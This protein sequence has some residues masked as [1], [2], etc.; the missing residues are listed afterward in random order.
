MSF[1][2]PL[3]L[4]GAAAVALPILY[5][6]IRRS[7][8]HQLEFSSLLFLSPSPPR[9]TRRSRIEHWLL[10]LL[11][12]TALLLIA[13]A[14][15]RPLWRNFAEAAQSDLARRRVAIA[16]DVS[17]SM[18]RPGV[19]EDVQAAVNDRLEQLNDTDQ[20]ALYTFGETTQVI[21]P[22]D[23]NP[24]ED[25]IATSR[26]AVRDAL[27]DLKPGWGRSDLGS[28]MLT[29]SDRLH[30]L[31]AETGPVD[32]RELIVVG[33]HQQGT[34]L[35]VLRA[36]D[37]P[38]SVE[39]T[40]IRVG[41]HV[42][43]NAA[44]ELLSVNPPDAQGEASI[45]LRISNSEFSDADQFSLQWFD[46]DEQSV[47]EPITV[48]VPAGEARFERLTWPTPEFTSGYLLLQGDE[49]GFDNRCYVTRT[50][51]PE[52]QL[53]FVGPG[54]P[55]DKQTLPFY[56][57]RAFQSDE[58]GSEKWNFQAIKSR[59]LVV[60]GDGETN[61]AD[62]AV[63][64]LE[65]PPAEHSM[66][67]AAGQ[68][69]ADAVSRI[70]DWIRA[71]G[72]VLYV[73]L[74]DESAVL[75]SLSGAL[76]PAFQESEDAEY[77]LLGQLDFSHPV[78]QPFSEPRFSDFTQIRFRHH[79]QITIDE[80]DWH[81]IARFDNRDP[82]LLHRN[83]DEGNLFVLTSSWSPSD[84]RLA[85]S[86]KF[87]PLLI[88][89]AEYGRART[90][91]STNHIHVNES[92]LARLGLPQESPL[93][94]IL[95]SESIPV[96]EDRPQSPGLYD[97]QSSSQEQTTRTAVNL[98]GPEGRLDPLP[99][100]VFE[101]LGIVAPVDMSTPARVE[102][103]RQLKR[104]ELEAGQKYWRTLLLLAIAVLL[105]E[106]WLAKRQ[107]LRVQAGVEVDGPQTATTT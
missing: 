11:R 74:D 96:A 84:S 12:A 44:I 64:A 33:D 5:H 63:A 71:G 40:T 38:E 104:Q 103:T 57:K 39:L 24:Q 46:A 58:S 85:L 8:K 22:F 48:Y 61:V 59:Q 80:Q 102:R 47:G 106:T 87:I 86:S 17:A 82:A 78:L 42:T 34:Q 98:F 70:R 15:A 73:C 68:F 105:V 29:I 92:A 94:P 25:Q 23:A 27:A 95:V 79:R 36:Y 7:P 45:R 16:V 99:E 53:W 107:S 19:W 26:A 52:R 97:Y 81:V 20:V 32:H 69:P 3:Y 75:E 90:E 89:M 37:W 41:Q 93:V 62:N 60:P 55:D 2:T 54:D 67:V 31:D 51:P 6:L 88:S 30:S 65:L 91:S 83:V 72:C 10:L 56:L 77:R 4:I 49:V 43:T 1:L 76:I 100:T 101:Q 66:L 13:F 28:A 21:V 50:V 14:F 18:R 9:I 35:E